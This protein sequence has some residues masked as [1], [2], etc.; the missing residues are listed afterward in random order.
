MRSA[1]V[2]KSFARSEGEVSAHLTLA[3]CAASSA[4]STSAASDLATS[5][6]VDPS[7]GL[8]SVK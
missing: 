7:I 8:L 3:A 4:R 1:I 2:F 5:Q 6:S